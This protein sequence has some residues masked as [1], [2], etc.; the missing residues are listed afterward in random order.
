[1]IFKTSNVSAAGCM[2]DIKNVTFSRFIKNFL[3]TSLK[4]NIMTN[5]VVLQKAI[6]CHLFD[7]Y[8]FLVWRTWLKPDKWIKLSF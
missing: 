2:M 5:F 8:G 3:Q 1:M 7:K 6:F 4:K